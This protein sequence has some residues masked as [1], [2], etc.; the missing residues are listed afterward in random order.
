ME[1]SRGVSGKAWHAVVHGGRAAAVAALLAS[2]M[3][4]SPAGA[5]TP[6]GDIDIAVTSDSMLRAGAK[7]TNEGANP[8]VSVSGDGGTRIV[9]DFGSK[10]SSPPGPVPSAVLR[11][12]VRENLGNWGQGKYISVYPLME[13]FT[14]GNRSDWGLHPADRVRGTGAGVTW[15]CASDT[16]IANQGTNCADG[17][18]GGEL[19]QVI[20]NSSE[21]ITDTTAGTI[22]LDVTSWF[23]AL[24]TGSPMLLLVKKD[25]DGAPG[26]VDFYSWE[27]APAPWQAP[28]LRVNGSTPCLQSSINC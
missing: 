14:E 16:N 7:N 10:P 19:G 6:I 28:T 22:E 26:R 1:G 18:S 9:L 2:A 5:I 21:L 15:N 12:T 3:L 13:A 20:P 23:N 24:P 4:A 27:G 8:V 17:W 25:N 11:L